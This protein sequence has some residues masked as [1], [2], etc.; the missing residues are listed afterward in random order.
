[1]FDPRKSTT[2]ETLF[3]AGVVVG[4]QKNAVVSHSV[5]DGIP[6][7]AFVPLPAGSKNDPGAVFHLCVKPEGSVALVRVRKI[8]D[9]YVIFVEPRP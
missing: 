2:G 6:Q 3:L 5:N 9:N 8:G 4:S 7:L 1:M